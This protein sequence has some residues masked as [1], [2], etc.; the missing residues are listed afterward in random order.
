[1]LIYMKNNNPADL[2]DQQGLYY[3]HLCI[4]QSLYYT[5]FGPN[6]ISGLAAAVYK[7]KGMVYPAALCYI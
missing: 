7:A 1:M 3:H 5:L 4:R 2:K 6:S